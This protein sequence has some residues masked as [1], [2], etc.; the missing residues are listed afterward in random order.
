MFPLRNLYFLFL[1]ILQPKPSPS[2]VFTV[3]VT[4]PAPELTTDFFLRL[5]LNDRTLLLINDKPFY[6]KFEDLPPYNLQDRI[7]DDTI[8]RM[9]TES[10]DPLVKNSV[11]FDLI[12]L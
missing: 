10:Y 8:H 4:P 5:H 3:E 2:S 9:L 6:P 7:R 12:Y 1:P 11:M